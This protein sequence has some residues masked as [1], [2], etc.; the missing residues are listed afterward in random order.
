MRQWLPLYEGD[1]YLHFPG[2][3]RSPAA[4]APVPAAEPVLSPLEIEQ[5]ARALRA[6]V[7]RG[8]LSVALAKISQ[9]S[10]PPY[11]RELDRYLAG[12]TDLADLERR[13]V[14]AER[15]GLLRPAG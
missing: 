12:S 10:R 3:V 14:D 4:G 15:R 2:I 13:M 8:W 7:V 9:W 1:G 5:R 11:E 6:G